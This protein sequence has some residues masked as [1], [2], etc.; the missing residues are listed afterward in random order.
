MS[1]PLQKPLTAEEMIARVYAGHPVYVEE[2]RDDDAFN[3]Y[4]LAEDVEDAVNY[5]MDEYGIGFRCWISKPTDE[6]R[7]SAPWKE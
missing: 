1:M 4:A 6:E 5:M 3:G 2:R 7:A